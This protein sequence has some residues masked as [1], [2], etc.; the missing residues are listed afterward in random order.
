MISGPATDSRIIHSATA[1]CSEAEAAGPVDLYHGEWWVIHTKARHEKALAA[2]LQRREIGCFLPLIRTLR[3][4]GDRKVQVE[5]PLF[6]SYLVLCGGES[7]RYLTLMTHRVANVIKVASQERL[8]HELR[9]IYRV[10]ASDQP[11]DL[12]PRLQ[13]GQR[14]RIIR[15]SLRGLEGIVVR[16][17]DVCRIYLGV[18]VLG[19]SAEVEID[20]S[21]VEAID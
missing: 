12:Y 1:E 17:R 14:C 9:Q 16:R 8:K 3:R 10:T 19:Q 6:P 15:G 11:V 21:S 13:R 4:H 5:L 18:D 2:D 20:A 7:E